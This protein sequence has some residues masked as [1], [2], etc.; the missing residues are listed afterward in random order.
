MKSICLNTPRALEVDRMKAVPKMN[1][2]QC[3]LA[4]SHTA[5]VTKWSITTASHLNHQRL[6]SNVFVVTHFEQDC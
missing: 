2:V 1:T 6:T 4:E 3:N 5:V